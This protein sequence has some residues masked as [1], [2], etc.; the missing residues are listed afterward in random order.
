MMQMEETSEQGL[1]LTVSESEGPSQVYVTQPLHFMVQEG[2]RASHHY[3]TEE[4][5]NTGYISQLIKY[6]NFDKLPQS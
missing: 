1:R 6:I 4:W 2:L 5:V 3:S